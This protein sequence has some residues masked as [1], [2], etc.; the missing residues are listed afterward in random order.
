M[1]TL[2]ER[3]GRLILPADTERAWAAGFFDGEGHARLVQSRWPS[4]TVTQKDTRPLERFRAAMGGFGSIT[5]RRDGIYENRYVI[6]DWTVGSLEQVQFC[7]CLLWPYLCQPKREQIAAV[8]TA[9]AAY[10]DTWPAG[11][12]R[13]GAKL[14]VSQVSEIQ[15]LLSS[16]GISQAEI[17]RR[18]GVN[19]TV[20]SR[21]K[22]GKRRQSSRR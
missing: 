15:A 14:T 22:L 11:L 21:I 18:Y 6:H 7:V 17:A 1:P 12:Q 16:G 2:S 13:P 20:I 5:R 9:R 3:T 4:L 10:R 8:L 19:Q